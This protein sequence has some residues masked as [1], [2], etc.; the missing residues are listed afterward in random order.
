MSSSDHRP[1]PVLL[2]STGVQPAVAPVRPGSSQR[3]LFQRRHQYPIAAHLR[4]NRPGCARQLRA[5]SVV[6]V[7]LCPECLRHVPPDG[8]PTRPL[9]APRAIRASSGSVS[10]PDSSREA[11]LHPAGRRVRARTLPGQCPCK[12]TGTGVRSQR[13]GRWREQPLRLSPKRIARGARA[14]SRVD[15][16]YQP[17]SSQEQP[18]DDRV[19]AVNLLQRPHDHDCVHAEPRA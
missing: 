11:C 18:V 9:L 5:G 4:D 3:R 1:G 6:G 2:Q 7:R 8:A 16:R 12:V 14:L 15:L 10:R 13:P 19:S 17:A